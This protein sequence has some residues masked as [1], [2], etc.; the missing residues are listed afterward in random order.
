VFDHK[1]RPK[2]LTC[3]YG[4][5][6]YTVKNLDFGK[7]PYYELYPSIM[8]LDYLPYYSTIDDPV[9]KDIAKQLGTQLEG[10]DDRIKSA[11][12]LSLVQQNVKYVSDESR[13]GRDIW[14]LPVVTL[15]HLEADCDGMASLYTSIAHNLGLDVVTVV[16]TGHMC[17]A[18]NMEWAHGTSYKLDGKKYFHVETTADLPAAGRFWGSGEFIAISKPDEPT[19]QFI[20][21]LTVKP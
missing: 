9:I 17:S 12:V 18:I 19:R 20:K 16:I 2:T 1:T 4:A 7:S 15:T 14:E 5:T 21:T 3:S 6:T 13:F 10:R 8:S 11:V